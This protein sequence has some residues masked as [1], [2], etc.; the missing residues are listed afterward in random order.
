VER[1][2]LD[3][4]LDTLTD[5]EL[6][7]AIIQLTAAVERDQDA[8]RYDWASKRRPS[9]VY[10]AE[11]YMWLLLAGRGFGKTRTAAEEVRRRGEARPL[12]IAVVHEGDRDV[13]EI[14]FEHPTSGLLAVI[15]PEMIRRGRGG[16][17]AYVES[18]GDTTLTLVNGTIFRAFSSNDPDR[19]RG[20]AFD[21]YWCEEFAAWGRN[22][23][24]SKPTAT[25]EQLDFCLREA[26]DP[27]GIITTTPRRVRH[28]REL[29]DRAKDPAEGIRVTHGSTYEN[30]DNLSPIQLARLERRYGS[31]ALGQQELG[32]IM[33]DEVEGAL[34]TIAGLARA[35]WVG[36]LPEFVEKITVV[37]PSGSSEGDATGIV[38]VGRARPGTR[39]PAADRPAPETAAEVEAERLRAQAAVLDDVGPIVVLGDDSTQGTPEHRYATICRTAHRHGVGTIG[40]ESL[41]GGDNVA[42]GIRQTWAELQRQGEI[43]AS[44]PLP[45][46]LPMTAKGTKIDRAQPVAALYPS[47]GRPTTGVWH[48]DGLA[49]LEE[50][51]TTYEAVSTWSPNRMDALVYGVR[52]FLGNDKG[53]A[54]VATSTGIRRPTTARLGGLGRP[55]RGR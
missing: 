2:N 34:W 23:K 5:E 8:R 36:P 11:A 16:R 20:F 47:D 15:P 32:G 6:E 22:S 19:L 52:H 7:E 3:R 14:C 21:G 9:Q 35:R 12:H 54:T 26:E 25:L 43:P 27:F 48:V 51:Q 31:G 4:A 49:E 18:S 33:L 38:T 1:V 13:R 10:P 29:L 53:P 45:A 44:E 39:T 50:E 41:Y 37:D 42:L 28:V 30:R 55:G 40:Y 17:R 24:K 46:L